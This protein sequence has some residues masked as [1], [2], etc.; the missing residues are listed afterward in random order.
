METCLGPGVVQYVCL[1]NA[2][3]QQKILL[4]KTKQKKKQLKNLNESAS[5]SSSNMPR[6]DVEVQLPSPSHMLAVLGISWESARLSFWLEAT[7]VKEK[8]V[9][10]KSS[11][12]AQN[13]M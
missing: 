5:N 10:K 9:G 7:R 1:G 2:G 13:G 6:P 3:E 12:G 4:V 11:E 8:A